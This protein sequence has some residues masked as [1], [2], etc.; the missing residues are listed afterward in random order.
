VRDNFRPGP[1]HLGKFSRPCG[2]I[3]IAWVVLIIPILCFPAVRGPSA[4]LMNWTCVVYGGVMMIVLVW[5]AV[6]ARKWFRGP[7]VFDQT[8]TLLRNR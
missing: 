3:A 1:W 6:N 8:K 2:F 7:K 5:Y 4:D